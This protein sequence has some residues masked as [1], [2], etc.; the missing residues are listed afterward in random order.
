MEPRTVPSADLLYCRACMQM[1]FFKNGQCEVCASPE[2]LAEAKARL[3]EA[4]NW[5]QFGEGHDEDGW[6]C[7]R[8]TEL[9]DEVMALEMAAAPSRDLYKCKAQP[10]A[11]PPQ[12]CDW[13]VCGCE[14]T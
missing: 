2:G 14:K 7:K 1:R 4:T 11:D 8:E 10:T 9:R 13:P 5:H 6:C 3:S 12:D